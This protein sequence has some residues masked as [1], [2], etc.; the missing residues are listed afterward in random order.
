MV[1]SLLLALL[2]ITSHC[3]SGAQDPTAPL[4]WLSAPEKPKRVQYNVPVLQSIICQKDSPCIAIL[5]DKVISSGESIN[6]YRINNIDEKKV[7]LTRGSKTW[8]LEL[9]TQVIKH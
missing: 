9:F 3:A 4:G 6:G 2:V 1:K 5:N 7:T 8:H